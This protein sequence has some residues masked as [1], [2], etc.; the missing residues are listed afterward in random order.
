MANRQGMDRFAA[1]LFGLALAALAG[2]LS[3]SIAVA[4]ELPASV[5]IDDGKGTRLDLNLAR[6]V[7]GGV[8]VSGFGWRREHPMGGGGA[9]HAGI[10]IRA[11]RGTP[12][13][14]AAAGVVAEISWGA[15]FGRFVRLRHSERL[16]TVYA[17]LRRVTRPLKVGDLMMPEDIIGQVGSTGKST[18][19]HLHFEVR[20]NGK[21]VDPLGVRPPR[22]S[23]T[24]TATVKAREPGP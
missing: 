1:W 15:D 17:H 21:P 19:P 6:V 3:L 23:K 22:K 13:R 9:S 20:R 4:A 7:E 12:V 5:T 24:A 2:G 14:A 10:D 8:L 11:P 16:D 18:G